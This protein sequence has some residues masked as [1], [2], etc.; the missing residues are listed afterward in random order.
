M[1]T[2][3]TLATMTAGGT[4]GQEKITVQAASYT[5]GTGGGTVTVYVEQTGG[6]QATVNG[7]ILKDASGNTVAALTPAGST[8]NPLALTAG[9]LETITGA[10]TG[11]VLSG[12]YSVTVTTK[13]GGSF[14]S[15]SVTA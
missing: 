7:L 6:P 9:T 15:Q 13:A 1:F 5:A 4:A 3:G 11:S 2:S 10:Y 8:G 14:V 12:S